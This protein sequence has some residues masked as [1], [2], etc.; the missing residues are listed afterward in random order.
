MHFHFA[1]LHTFRTGLNTI[2]PTVVLPSE[3]LIVAGIV[4]DQPVMKSFDSRTGEKLTTVILVN[5]PL[6]MTQVQ[7]AGKAHLALISR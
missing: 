6:S 2:S 1:V 3:T 7:V 4:D 5:I